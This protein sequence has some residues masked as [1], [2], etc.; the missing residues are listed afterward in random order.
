MVSTHLPCGD[1]A[2]FVKD[3]EANDDMNNEY[4][5]PESKRPRI[6]QDLNRTGAKPVSGST[7]DPLQPGVGYHSVGQLR[8]KPGRGH[9]TL[10]LSCSDKLLKWNLLGLQGSLGSYLFQEKIFLDTIIIIGPTFNRY[11]L[12]RALF[13]RANSLILHTNN[14]FNV[15]L[16][17][18]FYKSPS[19]V[20]PSPDSIVWMDAANIKEG[21]REALTEGHRQG[22]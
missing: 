17:Y 13:K 21:Y 6:L 12:E 9:P 20:N 19:R 11:S 15:D 2:I 8:T 16:K 4:N 7:S 22:W 5:E 10:S 18:D 14:I 1:A 3:I